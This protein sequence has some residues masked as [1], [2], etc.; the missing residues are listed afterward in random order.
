M[1]KILIVEDEKSSALRLQ[2][3]ILNHTQF[4]N[5]TFDFADTLQIACEKI[6]FNIYDLIFLDLNLNSKNGFDIFQYITTKSF[7]TIIVSAHVDQAITAFEHGVL[8]FVPK[9]VFKDRL[10][11]ALD[12][13]HSRTTTKRATQKLFVK[14]KNKIEAISLE[15]VLYFKPADHYTE[16]I[17][18]NGQKKLHNLSLDKI[19]KILPDYFERTHRSFIINVNYVDGLW[20]F[21]G[22]KYEVTLKNSDKLPVGRKYVK[23]LKAKIST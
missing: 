9:P 15:S 21:P 16:I 18:E 20:S 13:V 8:D 6:S 1:S 5:A 19:Y 2:K 17:L 14:N 10:H 7:L 22:S 23:N 11:K 4:K 3:L 12:K